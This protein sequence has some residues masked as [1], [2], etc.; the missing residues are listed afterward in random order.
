[1]GIH[2]QQQKVLLIEILSPFTYSVCD[3]KVN[4]WNK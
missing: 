1:M 2:Q 3:E 4:K